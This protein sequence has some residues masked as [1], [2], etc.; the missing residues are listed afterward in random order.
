MPWEHD[1]SVF[2]STIVT[3]EGLNVF[4]AASTYTRIRIAQ[5][6]LPLLEAA[7]R[8]TPLARVVNVAGG[9]KEGNI[10]ISDLAAMKMSLTSVRP[11]LTS[12]HTLAL[13][14]LA[15][16]SPTVSFVHDFP[17][18]V[19]TALHKDTTGLLAFV[20]RCLIDAAYM[21]LGTWL[22]VP[23][24]ESG[25]RH[26]FL[27][28]SASFPP[29]EGTAA[30]ISADGLPAVKGSNGEQKSGVYSVDWDC[31]GPGASAETALKALRKKGVQD[32]VWNHFLEKFEKATK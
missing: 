16:Q 17:G 5:Q 15:L 8:T 3:P 19:Y 26:V 20:F 6:L 11:H 25:E 1:C 21:L 28:T 30:G 2:D 22:F 4:L 29:R 14:H 27:A 24:G 13:E 31:Q 18:A 23:I 12:M 32:L 10:D 7:A 9:T